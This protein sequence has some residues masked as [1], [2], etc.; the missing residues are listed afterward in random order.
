MGRGIIAALRPTSSNMSTA[1]AA[2]KPISIL[3]VEDRPVFREGLS[4]IGHGDDDR[5]VSI[6]AS[7]LL[8]ARNIRRATRR[9]DEGAGHGLTTTVEDRLDV[10]LLELG[11]VGGGLRVRM[12]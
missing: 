2:P 9:T 12:P 5:I 8:A 4:T 1:S 3:S 7:A 11:R 6:A 10:G